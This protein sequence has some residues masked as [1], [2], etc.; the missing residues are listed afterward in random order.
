MEKINEKNLYKFALRNGTA[1]ARSRFKKFY[2]KKVGCEFS[3]KQERYNIYFNFLES[4][5]SSIDTGYLFETDFVAIYI[6]EGI[7]KEIFEKTLLLLRR[8]TY[9]LGLRIIKSEKENLIYIYFD[10]VIN[11]GIY[12]VDEESS[13]KITESIRY[14]EQILR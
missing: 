3:F 4:V 1:T 6:P 9:Y 8:H 13:K 2:E 12:Y 7:D 5:W 14:K 11:K 10:N